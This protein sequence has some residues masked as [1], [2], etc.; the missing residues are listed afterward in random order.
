MYG[1]QKS[2]IFA[3]EI[4]E[5]KS[6]MTVYKLVI[7][8]IFALCPVLLPAYP[9]TANAQESTSSVTADDVLAATRLANE[10]LVID[11]NQK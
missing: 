8:V 11:L 4:E 9:S 7:A 3:R 10:G 5:L 2:I 1:K 6:I